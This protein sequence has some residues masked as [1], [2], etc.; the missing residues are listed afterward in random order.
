MI[1]KTRILLITLFLSSFAFGQNLIIDEETGKY[2]QKAVVEI[3]NLT[4]KDIYSKA[5]EWITLNYKSADDVIQSK[6][7]ENGKIILKGNFSTSLFMKQGWIKH[8]LILEFKDNKFRYAY[9][10]L[11][12]YSTGSGE[13]PFEKNMMSKK[14]VL[15][16]TE[17][18]IESS[19]KDLTG[20]IK[21]TNDTQ[22][23]W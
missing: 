7:S 21:K 23:D 1:M 15:A 11:S 20:H 19:I 17:Q 12:Y 3:N 5:I 16:E 14:K 6:D 10:D 8:T 22:D 9:T 13:V 18:N 2:S 4:K